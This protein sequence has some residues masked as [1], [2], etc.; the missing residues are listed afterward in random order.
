MKT[1]N[2]NNRTK[3]V[4]FLSGLQTE[5]CVLDYVNIDDLE[6]EN[7]Q[8]DYFD[9]LFELI[10]ENGGVNQE[11]IYYASAIE[12]LKENDPSLRESMELASDMGFELKNLNSETLAS[13]L[14]TENVRN[15]FYELRDEINDFFSEL[16]N[17]IEE[18]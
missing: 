18:E 2:E 11:V 16:Y 7:F 13:I 4:E 1:L 8:N 12:Y 6:T 9:E 17:D 10:E 3:L 14:K 15:E 5:I